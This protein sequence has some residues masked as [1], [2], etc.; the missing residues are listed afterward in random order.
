MQSS[1]RR[2]SIAFCTLASGL[3]MATNAALAQYPPA[4]VL[5]GQWWQ[6]TLSAPAS[7]SPLLDNTGQFVAVNQQG[8]I[9]FLAGNQGGVTTRTVTIPAGKALFFPIV[10]YFDV[11]DGIERG[12]GPV[13]LAP[14]PLQTAQ[15]AVLA[16][17]WTATNLSCEVDG[18]PLP[19]TAANLEQSTPFSFF[20]PANNIFG[21]PAGVYF[22]AFDSG[23]YVLL[24]PLS[25]GSHRIHFAGTLTS[26]STSVDV[27]YYLTVQ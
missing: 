12:V 23:Y 24:K 21:V 16:A 22:P 13:F 7:Q 25:A 6:W 19:I 17:I 9:W 5:A 15:Q 1:L 3:M 8:K 27:T 20:L 11:E 18:I 10:N 26:S 2:F 4:K 14:H